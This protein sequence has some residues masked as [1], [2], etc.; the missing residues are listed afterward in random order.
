M[1]IRD[2]REL[3]AV[4][5]ATSFFFMLFILGSGFGIAVLGMV[6]SAVGRPHEGQGQRDTRVGLWL[7]SLFG[8]VYY[9][10]LTLPTRRPV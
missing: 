10:Q 7:S 9:I 8:P 1:C 4:V 5:L 3:A 2:R 6:A